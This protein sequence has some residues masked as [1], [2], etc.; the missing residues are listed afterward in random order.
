MFSFVLEINRLTKFNCLK[1]FQNENLW[2]MKLSL[3]KF[4][5]ID[6]LIE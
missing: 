2:R 5:S 4:N 1:V 3:P 6:F